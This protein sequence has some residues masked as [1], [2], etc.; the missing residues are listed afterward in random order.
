MQ[1]KIKTQADRKLI[2]TLLAVDPVDWARYADGSL[3]FIS[4]TGQKFK[5][6]QQMLAVIQ[7]DIKDSKIAAKKA[8]AKDTAAKKAAS[9]KKVAGAA[10]K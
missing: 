3:T 4:P 7:Q 2:K 6:S 10:A 5:Y 8:A 1:D 9:K